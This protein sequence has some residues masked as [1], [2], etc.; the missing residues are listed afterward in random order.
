MVSLRII[1]LCSPT[2]S[3]SSEQC[4]GLVVVLITGCRCFSSPTAVARRGPPAAVAPR[5]RPP[6][7]GLR[8]PSPLVAGLR[9]SPLVAGL[10]SSP[11]VAAAAAPRRGRL[12]LGCRAPSL[13]VCFP[14]RIWIGRFKKKRKKKAS[15]ALLLLCSDRTWWLYILG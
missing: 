7:A 2:S 15:L 6:M 10:R 9:P 1:H 12:R 4:R 14:I 8:P 3:I 11:L 13:G 5:C